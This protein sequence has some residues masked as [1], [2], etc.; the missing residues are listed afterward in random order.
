MQV[1]IEHVFREIGPFHLS[2]KILGIELFII[3]LYYPSNAMES[4]VI[5]MISYLVLV[6]YVFSLC[7]LVSLATESYHFKKS[8]QR[9]S[10]WVSL[11]FSIDFNLI[12]FY[13][14]FYCFFSS[15]YFEFNLFSSSGFVTWKLILLILDFSFL[16][17]IYSMLYSF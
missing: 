4:V 13:S 6:N 15:V 16:L 9:T 1:S 11:V 5:A 14:E 12:D 3:F 8:F 7:S 10:F 17:C 2:Y